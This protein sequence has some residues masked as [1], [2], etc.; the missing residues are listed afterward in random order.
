MAKDM[1]WQLAACSTIR[2][3]HDVLRQSH[4]TLVVFKYLDRKPARLEDS[5]MSGLKFADVAVKV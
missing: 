4:I 5:A 3:R 1:K 2:R